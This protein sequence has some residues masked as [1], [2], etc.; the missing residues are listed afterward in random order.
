MQGTRGTA[1][2]R[3]AGIVG[4]LPDGRRYARFLLVILDS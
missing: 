4:A 3:F 2:C 1:A